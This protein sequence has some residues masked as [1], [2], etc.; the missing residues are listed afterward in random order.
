MNTPL[1][2]KKQK[3][4]GLSTI[5]GSAEARRI[6]ALI[7]EVMAGLRGPGDA[8]TVMGVNLN[9]YYMLETRSLQGMTSAL[10]PIP[11]G[12]RRR[13]PENEIAQ[14][15]KEIQRLERELTRTSALVRAAQRTIGLPA[16]NTSKKE[17]AKR[18]RKPV[19]R[20][21]KAAQALREIPV[22]ET[23]PPVECPKQEGV[24]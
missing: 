12:R 7:L 24:A 14:L 20:A 19:I 11:K 10:E 16:P 8:A 4:F 9:R 2:V 13:K 17:G 18:Y 21:A 3:K 6:T 1:P 15:K 5:K 22:D 23:V